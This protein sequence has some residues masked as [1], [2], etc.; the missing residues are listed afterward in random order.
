MLALLQTP[1]PTQAHASVLPCIY[2]C[3]TGCYYTLSSRCLYAQLYVDINIWA[4]C[5]ARIC[6]YM[7]AYSCMGDAVSVVVLCSWAYVAWRK[8]ARI[9]VCVRV[10]NYDHAHKPTININTNRHRHDKTHIHIH[11]P[12]PI[13]RHRQRHRH[14]QT[15]MHMY[16]YIYIHTYINIY[17][18]IYILFFDIPFVSIYLSSSPSHMGRVVSPRR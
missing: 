11:I 3:E 8:H 15:C 5:L 17:I 6:T 7:Y 12:I 9:H 2:E 4:R 14:R 10:Y 16:I 13:R 18:C 1:K